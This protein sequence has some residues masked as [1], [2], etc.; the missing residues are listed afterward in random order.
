VAWQVNWKEVTQDDLD[1]IASYIAEDSPNYAAA[2]V[3]EALDATQ[4]LTHLAQR[5]RIVPE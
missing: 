3:R 4:S 2:F 1:K 5:G